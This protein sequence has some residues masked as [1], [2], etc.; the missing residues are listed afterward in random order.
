MTSWSL[1]WIGVIVASAALA[2]FGL[3]TMYVTE[4]GPFDDQVEPLSV[5]S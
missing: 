1:R 4:A 2:A 5:K 3:I